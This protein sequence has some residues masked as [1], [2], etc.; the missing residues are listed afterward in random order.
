[1]LFIEGGMS[2]EN[3]Q[4]IAVKAVEVAREEIQKYGMPSMLQF[5]LSLREGERLANELNANNYIVEIGIALMDVMLGN[6]A[7]NGMQKQHV[8]LSKEYTEKFLQQFDLSKDIVNNIIN[9]VEAHH[10]S[11]PFKTIEAEICANADCYRFVH[12]KG[13][14]YYF[15]VLERRFSDFDKVLNQVEAKLDEKINIASI[16][17]V[18]IELQQYYDIFK[19]YIG[20]SREK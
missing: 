10:G 3:L 13:V 19:N 18:K 14:L 12:P 15:T 1:M 16:P 8:E 11:V 20:L 4:Q 17:S 6:A 9:C 7:K 5:D 2:M